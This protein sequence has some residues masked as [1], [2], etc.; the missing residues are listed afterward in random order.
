MQ[1]ICQKQ[2]GGKN[3]EYFVLNNNKEN[4][5]KNI[6]EASTFKMLSYFMTE[7]PKL[8][9]GTILVRFRLTKMAETTKWLPIE[10]S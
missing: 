2:N 1:N 8:T 9:F 3:Y 4:I 5:L 7:I 6:F 10:R